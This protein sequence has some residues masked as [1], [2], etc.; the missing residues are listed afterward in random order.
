M[1]EPSVKEVASGSMVLTSGDCAPRRRGPIQIAQPARGIRYLPVLILLVA[2]AMRLLVFQAMAGHPERFLQPD[3]HGYHELAANLLQFHHFGSPDE[4]G[5]WKPEVNRTPFYPAF[6]AANY[7]IFGPLPAAAILVQILISTL[8]VAL[9]YSLGRL[10]GSPRTGTLVATLMS[11][12]VGSVIYANQLMTETLFNCAFLGGMVIWSVMIRKKRWQYGFLSGLLLGLD[13]LVRPVLFYFGP[14]SGLL[15]VLLYPRG[16]KQWWRVALAVVLTFALVVTPWMIRNYSI[17]GRAELST[18]QSINLVFYNLAQLRAFQQGTSY[19]TARAHLNEEMQQETLD[20]QQH[21]GKLA[22]YYQ[23]K[24]ISEIRA[25]WPEYTFVHLKSSLLFF[26]IPTAS[27]VARAL[28]WVR[29]TRTGLLANLMA[30]GLLGTWQSFRDFHRQLSQPGY[31]DL[32]FF[33]TVGYELL[34]LALVNLGAVWGAIRCLRTRRWKVLLFTVTTI[35]YFAL[36][37]GPVSY[38]ARYRTPIMPFLA[39]LAALSLP[40]PATPRPPEASMLHKYVSGRLVE[41]QS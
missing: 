16:S 20:I 28:G 15:P 22:A 36:V 6:L 34:F 30:R 25:H 41:R 1:R 32:L 39:L 24:A 18:I 8:T 7:A 11:V 23:Q 26:V 3:S 9:A 38:D 29:T 37:T 35:G 19:T 40:Q 31:G 27:T 4:A 17:T 12:E 5:V 13:T 2:F 33:G 14:V 21:P 10:W